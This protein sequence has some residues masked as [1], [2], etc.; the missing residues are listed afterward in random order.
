MTKKLALI[1]SILLFFLTFLLFALSNTPPNADTLVGNNAFSAMAGNNPPQFVDSISGTPVQRMDVNTNENV[2][3]RIHLRVTDV[4][5]DGIDF[6]S[7]V[8]LGG[9]GTIQGISLADTSFRYTPNHNIYGTDSVQ[10]II[11]DNGVP[12]LYDTLKIIIHIQHVNQAPIIVDNNNNQVF[13]VSEKIQE[14]K[15]K[16]ICLNA[17]DVDSNKVVISL[18]LASPMNGTIGGY[19]KMCFTYTP[20]KDF[21]GNDSLVMLFSDNGSPILYNSIKVYL[22]IYQLN[23]PPVILNQQGLPSKYL[24]DTTAE[25]VPLKIC[26]N[27]LD[28]ENDSIKIQSLASLGGHIQIDPLSNDSLCFNATPIGLFYGNDSIEVIIKDNGY[29]E[30]YDTAIIRLHVWHHNRPPEILDNNNN[31]VD[32]LFFNAFENEISHICLSISDPDNDQVAITNINT[33]GS[34]STVSISTNDAKCLDYTPSDIIGRDKIVV[35]VCDNGEPPLCDS[36]VVIFNVVAKFII[37]QAM[38]PNEDGI[39]DV[40]L[41]GG[42]ERH[43]RNTVTIFSRWNDLVYKAQGYDNINVVWKGE[44][45]NGHQSNNKV[46]DGIYFYIIEMEDGSKLS[47]FIV[48]KR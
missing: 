4:D 32:T 45:N 30:L 47:G 39:N 37:T 41:I 9:K 38:S 10:V 33:A 22:R 6:T 18:I 7:I 25:T 14:N 27:A 40:W 8:S 34:K 23:T 26:L 29:P 16:Q 15:A 48:L 36:V 2:P 44:Y 42:I 5:P 24:L 3:V 17:Y 21:I 19:N 35:T 20:N 11:Q 1:S 31:A 13:S 43:P 28:H 12:Q 46:P